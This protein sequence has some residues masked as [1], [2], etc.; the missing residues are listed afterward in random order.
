MSE[1]VPQDL[2]AARARLAA[3]NGVPV[4]IDVPVIARRVSEESTATKL[5]VRLYPDVKREERAEIGIAWVFANE[6][7]PGVKKS[8]Y[9]HYFLTL[10]R[11]FEGLERSGREPELRL[12]LLRAV[13]TQGRGGPVTVLLKFIVAPEYALTGSMLETIYGCPLAGFYTAFVG[14]T[15]DP[16][17]DLAAPGYTRGNAVHA[18]YR[19]AAEAFQRDRGVE[20]TRVAY[21][22]GVRESW[23]RDLGS[24]LMD[25]PKSGPRKLHRVPVDAV[26]AVLERCAVLWPEGETAAL[27]HERLVYSPTR[28]LSG[29]IDRLDRRGALIRL[30]E[31]KT[32]GGFGQERDPV[33]GEQHAGGLQALAYREL[34]LSAGGVG[35]EVDA[36]VE[37]LETA[38]PSLLPLRRHPVVTRARATLEA[39]DDRGLDLLA[40]TR[41]VGY[42]AGSGLLT[43]Y[44]RHR[45]DEVSRRGRHLAATGGDWNLYA[46]SAPCPICP[47]NSR[48]VCA[49]TR[50]GTVAP[51]DNLFRYA[52]PE[53]FAYWARF[54]HQMRDEDRRSRE[55]FYQLATTPVA[56]LEQQGVTIAGVHVA[57]LDGRTVEFARDRPFATRMREDDRVLVS[58]SGLRPGD[59]SSVEGTIESLDEWAVRVALHDSLPDRDRRYRIDDL[60]RHGMPDWQSQ[61]LTDF[62][63]SAME[64]TPVRG[65]ELAATELPRLAQVI[66]GSG[67]EPGPLPANPAVPDFVT[68]LNATQRRAVG[69]AL[70]LTPEAGEPLLIQGP[71]GTGKTTMIAELVHAI[72]VAEFGRDVSG[73]RERPVLLLANSHRAVDELVLKL[74]TRYPDLAPFV[75]RVGRVRSDTDPAVRARVLGEAIGGRE[76]LATLDLAADGAQRLVA[77]IREGNLLHDQAMIFAGTLAAAQSP[78][79]RSL[80]F[81]TVIVDEC[82]QATEP[83]ALQALR[84]MG[85]GFQAR[86]IL[87]GDHRQL[88]PVVPEPDA[89]N[90]PARLAFPPELSAS[91]L[92]ADHTLRTSLF[93][94][95]ADKYPHRVIT[96]TEQYRM[97]EPICE[98]VSETFYGGRLRPGTSEVADRRVGDWLAAENLGPAD[99]LVLEAPPLLFIDT[100]DDPRA[101]DREMAT[102]DDA[103]ANEREA[104]IIASLVAKLVQ[105]RSRSARQHLL[106]EVG[107]ISP[108]RRQ[109]NVIKQALARHDPALAAL[110]RVD[111]VDR[112]QG[113]EKEIVL[114]SLTNSNPQATI[115]PL[116]ADWRRM[117]VAIS[118]AR[119]TMVLVGSRRTFTAP[120][121]DAE[122]EAKE[123]YRCLFAGVDRLSASGGS[124]ILPSACVDVGS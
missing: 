44:D 4:R 98:V 84:H 24:L 104:A 41:N 82:G 112:F 61:G 59:A 88:P 62:L 14:V 90:P 58:L 55:W 118:R 121:V 116:H 111:T 9:S 113:G 96:L 109:N 34:L 78:E 73:S 95:L 83:A 106:S 22:D 72:A 100:S 32:G 64:A 50:R 18:G 52:P 35:A 33:T 79:L 28:G 115:G 48:G 71:P 26:D 47:A 20:S 91:G 75:V 81:R 103:R 29:R 94:R 63:I 2:A 15:F 46:S 123:F 19:R 99:G 56:T 122:E 66:L 65:R 120:S 11:A 85:A 43:G 25:R 49:Q 93:E 39:D 42:V 17:R 92:T 97:N 23:S 1:P 31:I 86:L 119:R 8:G 67:T 53:L 101:A 110:V 107:V 80:S 70:A 51:L 45:L 102:R 105:G 16:K 69:A 30:T 40:Q 3:C 7:F 21:F 76:A 54:H 60:S 27:L 87:V 13:R 89:G 124:R 12:Q 57:R 114:I 74:G 68:G 117:N 36:F 108:Y 10:L 77:L 37:E 5:K 38:T 6:W